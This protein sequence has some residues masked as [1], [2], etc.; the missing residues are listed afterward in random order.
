MSNTNPSL[1]TKS[2]QGEQFNYGEALQKS[3]LFYEAQRSGA[4]PSDNRIDWR[5]NSGL[6]DGADVGKDLTGGYYD[7]GDHGKYG[8]PMAA[9]MTMLAWGVDEYR[10]AYQ[11]S[12]QLDEALEAIK[13][14]TDYILKAHETDAKGTKTFWGQVG[15]HKI[16]VNYWESPE[17]MT[18]ARPAYK[19][20]RQNPGSDLAGEASAAL[21][22]ASMAFRST[23]PGYA[24]QLLAEAKQL[25][26][27]ADKYRGKYSNSIPD[28]AS[29]YAS[30]DYKDELV[31]GATWLYKATG[32]KNYLNKAENYY[33]NYLGGLAPSGTQSWDNKSYGSAVLLAQETGKQKYRVDVEQWLDNWT[34]KSPG[35]VPYTSGGLAWGGQWA[36]LRYSANTAFVAGVYAD[37]VNNKG[38]RYSKFA[39]EQIDYILGDNP[40]NSSYVVGFG[41]NSPVRPHH[42]GSH[43]GS[44]N[45]FRNSE[46]NKHVL[47][48]ALV[49]GPGSANDFDYKDDRA[50]YV[51]NE[52][53]L[54][55]N[56]AFT[57]AVARMYDDFGGRPLNDVQLNSLPEISN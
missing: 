7:A 20:D 41:K 5:G 54:D 14:G 33:Q 57:G 56:A 19:I 31:W 49:G 42:R 23:N 10:Q 36:S 55:Y 22:S 18:M 12:G 40:R 48:G 16:D 24:N 26:E 8:F 13:W 11:R 6:K 17:E 51:R 30:Y 21:A 32:D 27:F 38:G 25:Y 50:D 34:D 39:N 47:Y 35:G 52:V 3:F 15:S 44:W 2:L 9:S 46:P 45:T 53:A 28:A 37:T 29:A 43:D 1:S 4:L